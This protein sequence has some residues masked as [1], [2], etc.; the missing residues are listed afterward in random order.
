[1]CD[2]AKIE[3]WAK[4]ALSRR[5]FGVVS[6]A[7]ALAACT[8]PAGEAASASKTGQ[9][10]RALSQTEVSFDTADGTM[11]AVFIH[12][13]SGE[14]PAVI[15]WPDI[16]GIRPSHIAMAERTAAEGYAVLLVNPYHRDI[17]GQVW[18]SFADFADGGFDR[19]R[20]LRS[21]LSSFAVRRDSQAIVAWLDGQKAVDT[22]RG[23]GAEGYCMGGPFTVYSAAEVPARVKAA[24]SFHGGGLVREDEESPHR[25]LASTHA[26]YLFAIARD[27]DD[28]APGDKTALREAAD[29]AGRPAVIR[30]YDGDHGWTVPDHRTYAL[31]AAEAAWKAKL[32]LYRAAL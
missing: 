32:E 23:I 27:D 4:E 28:E 9:P 19:A 17:K 6:G 20:E 2:R 30:V 1:M 31:A 21:K 25:L 14:H 10:L 13:A 8:P 5:E 7:A 15:H 18:A 22:A 11:D 3:S 16:A 12:P 29:A 24:A 26:H